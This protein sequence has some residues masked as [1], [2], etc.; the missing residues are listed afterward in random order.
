MKVK[1]KNRICGIQS[2]I[3]EPDCVDELE[4]VNGDSNESCVNCVLD[5]LSKIK[6]SKLRNS[7]INLLKKGNLEINCERTGKNYRIL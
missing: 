6:D 1:S 3:F 7:W 5:S 2:C 4:S